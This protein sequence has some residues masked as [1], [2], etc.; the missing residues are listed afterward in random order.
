MVSGH[1]SLVI[2]EGARELVNL[3]TR[4]LVNFGTY[5]IVHDR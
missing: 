2:G 4:K 3:R 1:W 5:M